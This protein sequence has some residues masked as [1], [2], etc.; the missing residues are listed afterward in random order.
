MR[1]LAAQ[2]VLLRLQTETGGN[3][4][5]WARKYTINKPQS[6]P[7]VYVVRGDGKQIYGRAGAPRDL[8]GFLKDQLKQSGKLLSAR[9]LKALYRNVED[10]QK[11]LKR[12][13]VQPAVEKVA[14][15]LDSGSY[16]LAAR[17]AATLSTMLTEKGTA[18]IEQAEKKLET[19]ETAFEGAL[20]LC[21]TSRLYSPLPS[22]KETLEKTLAAH[23]ENSAHGELIEPA[24]RVDAAQNLE[25]QGEWQQALDS[26]R[27]IAAAY[28]RTP[29]ASIAVEKVELLAARAAG[30]TKKTVTNSKTAS[31]PAGADEKRAA[32]SL[33]LGKL[34]IKRKPKKAREYFE[35]AIEQ[36]PTSDAAKEARELLKKL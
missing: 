17:Q 31:S 30:K 18:A 35:K 23:R 36:A 3:W 10:A 33:R 27:E 9:E 25:T 34:L 20:A 14:A 6:I 2:F 28:P 15:S 11:L 13:K 1:A 32:S 24:Q 5:A 8:I 16:A 4:H 22:L 12:G 7:K 29:A 26:Y 19:E 21:Q